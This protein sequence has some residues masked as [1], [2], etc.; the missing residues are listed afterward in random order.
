MQEATLVMGM[1]LQRFQFFDHKKYQLKLKES[2]SIK[3]DGFTLK[4][5][6]R[7]GRFGLQPGDRPADLMAGL[8]AS[9]SPPDGDGDG[10]PDA[11]ESS[12][13]T[14]PGANDSISVR[15]SGYTAIEEYINA[16]ADEVAGGAPPGASSGSS[17]DGGAGAGGALPDGGSAGGTNAGS[18]APGTDESGC[19]CTLRA[20]PSPTTP[21]A[22]AIAIAALARRFARRRSGRG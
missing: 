5:K 14:N 4:V 11:W 22:V 7:T 13:G 9:A 8:T 18:S 20:L 10:M 21:A 15:P 2:L 17:G 6:A 12:H 3:P 19:G 16:L 1:L